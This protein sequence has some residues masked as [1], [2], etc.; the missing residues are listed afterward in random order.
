LIFCFEIVL[1]FS[2]VPFLMALAGT[3]RKDFHE[4]ARTWSSRS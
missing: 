1:M 3:E 2:L 4:T